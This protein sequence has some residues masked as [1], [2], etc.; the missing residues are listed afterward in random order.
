MRSASSRPDC[1][2][3]GRRRTSLLNLVDGPAARPLLESAPCRWRSSASNWSGLIVTVSCAG[4]ATPGRMLSRSGPLDL[5][6]SA[7]VVGVNLVGTFNVFR[8]AAQRIVES[9]P[10]DGERGV[11]VAT[12]SVA[13]YD[14]QI[15]QAAYAASKGEVAALTLPAARELAQH[16]IRVVSIAPGLVRHPA[17]VRTAPGGS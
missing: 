17:H 14:G 9:E 12:S 2:A 16:L 10:V 6:A 4:V 3:A 7:R 1:R 8:L 13:A 15:G 11:L 5:D